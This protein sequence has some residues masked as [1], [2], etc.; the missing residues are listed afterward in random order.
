MKKYSLFALLALFFMVVASCGSDKNEGNSDELEGQITMSGAFALYPMAVQWGE[1]FKALHPKVNFD[2]QAG[3]AGKGITD[4][5]SGNT[6]IGMVSRDINAEEISKGAFDYSVCKDAVVPTFNAMNPY[7]DLIYQKGISNQQFIDI[8]ITEKIKT[9]G[10]LLGNG[11]TELIEIYTRSDA[12]GAA[13]SWAK[14]L[15]G[16]K[17]EDLKGVGVFGDPGIAQA[18]VKSKY[19]IG[20]NNVGFAY[21]SESKIP[22]P[23][24]SILPIDINA[25]GVLE[26]EENVYANVDNINAAIL[27]NIYPSPPARPLLFVSKGKPT[28]KLVIE[29][30]K[31][32]LTEGQKG[33]AAAGFVKL[34]DDI[35]QQQIEKIPATATAEVTN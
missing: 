24:M 25:N 11:S 12:A 14:Y 7:K 9:W 31:Y 27:A 34:P 33:V 4:V 35:I 5:L 19:A 18:V 6:D 16:K 28:N 23:G 21:D 20:F 15:G 22:N 32:V 2:I 26:P 29:F 1:E 17:Q 30:L 8:F 13:E 3:G 10:D